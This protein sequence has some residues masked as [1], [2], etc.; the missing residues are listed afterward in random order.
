MSEDAG[1]Q[2]WK[3]GEHIAVAGDTGTGKSYLISKIIELRNFVVF[4]RVKPDDIVLPG[5]R[6]VRHASAMDDGTGN[7]RILLDPKYPDQMREGYEML[8]R[9]WEQGGWTIVIDEEWYTEK[10]LKLG[11][12]VERLLTQGR[13]KH[14]SVVVGMQRPAQISRFVLS[15]ATHGFFFRLEGRDMQIVKES[16]TPRLVEP[17]TNLRG[18]EFAY[19][20]R[21]SRAVMVGDAKKLDRVLTGAARIGAVANV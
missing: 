1:P 11:E 20:N 8:E 2:T 5:F 10:R 19:Y 4:F 12:M 9:A 17:V 3:I 6:K 21:A 7:H 15:Q 18:H 13:S 16:M 14:I